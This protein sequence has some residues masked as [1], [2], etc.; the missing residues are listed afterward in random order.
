[1]R[2]SIKDRLISAAL[3][4]LF[5]GLMAGSAYFIIRTM[6]HWNVKGLG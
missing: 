1:M 6:M 2:A 4:V 5:L 3:I